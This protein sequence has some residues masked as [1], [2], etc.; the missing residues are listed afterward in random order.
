M[1]VWQNAAGSLLE[2]NVIKITG[3]KTPIV[4][5][6]LSSFVSIKGK[7]RVNVRKQDDGKVVTWLTAK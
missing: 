2:G 5:S 7:Y 4:T 6:R 3:V 1:S